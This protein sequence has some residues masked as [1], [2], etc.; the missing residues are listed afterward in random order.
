M[1]SIA[2]CEEV[3]EDGCFLEEQAWFAILLPAKL[4]GDEARGGSLGG[5]YD[6]LQFV[7]E[8]PQGLRAQGGFTIYEV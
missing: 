7:Y 1:A 3:R 4:G 8:L 5:G 6:L 2:R